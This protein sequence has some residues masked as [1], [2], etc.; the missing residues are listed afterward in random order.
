MTTLRVKKE[1]V[2]EVEVDLPFYYVHDLDN[3]VIYG[4]VEEDHALALQKSNNGVEY[5]WEFEKDIRGAQYHMCYYTK[6]YLSTKE[7]F[8]E[9]LAE[10]KA[11]AARFDT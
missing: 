7:E 1:V 6:G 9:A 5:S 3:T 4:K 8:E 2:E 10:A 11:F